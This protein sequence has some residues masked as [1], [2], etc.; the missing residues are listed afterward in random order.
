MRLPENIPVDTLGTAAIRSFAPARASM[1]RDIGAR[2]H[3]VMSAF[4][5]APQ[6]FSCYLDTGATTASFELPQ[7][8]IPPGVTR[9]VVGI[10]ARGRGQVVVKTSVDTNGIQFNHSMGTVGHREGIR[11]SFGSGSG[12]TLPNVSRTLVLA[13]TPSESWSMVTA[14]LDGTTYTDDLEIF[15]LAFVPQH[16]AR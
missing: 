11:W 3:A 15:G 16:L 4:G 8:R 9:C 5:G 7:I 1:L 12:G 13:S 6:I 2:Q 10:L 14:T